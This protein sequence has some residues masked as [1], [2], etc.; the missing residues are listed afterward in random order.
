MGGFSNGVEQ[1]YAMILSCSLLL[2]HDL[3]IYLITTYFLMSFPC[4]CV[5][6][7]PPLYYAGWGDS[8]IPV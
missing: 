5:T 2:S 3:T 6:P 7:L 8:F 1:S 4:D